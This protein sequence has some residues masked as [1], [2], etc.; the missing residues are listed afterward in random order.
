MSIDLTHVREANL[1]RF[2]STRTPASAALGRLRQTRGG[3]GGGDKQDRASPH[4]RARGVAKLGDQTQTFW[5]R[6]C[7][8]DF[9]GVEPVGPRPRLSDNDRPDGGRFGG[10]HLAVIMTLAQRAVAGPFRPSRPLARSGLTKWRLKRVLT[11]IDE[12]ICELI[13]RQPSS[14]R[15]T[16]QN[17]LRRAVSGS[18]GLQAP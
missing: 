9:D 16:E 11:Y 2:S 15:G 13:T 6:G 17:V 8:V 14:S 1:G 18:N 10:E 5:R 4:C 12:H 3:D 7:F